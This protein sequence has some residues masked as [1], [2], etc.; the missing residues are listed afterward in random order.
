MTQVQQ[1]YDTVEKS[2][3]SIAH[4]QEDYH[5]LF[6]RITSSYRDL[7]HQEGMESF[8]YEQRNGMRYQQQVIF[9][10][11]DEEVDVLQHK[12]R[13]LLQEEDDLAHQKRRLFL[14]EDTL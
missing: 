7:E 9:S 14:D 12:K 13:K 11:L 8:F 1:I 2:N 6:Q 3:Q 4:L 10:H 5:D